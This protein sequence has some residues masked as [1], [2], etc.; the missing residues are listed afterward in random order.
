[1]RAIPRPA[2]RVA[3]ATTAILPSNGLIPTSPTVLEPAE[4]Q[5]APRPP[6]LN[7]DGVLLLNQDLE[8]VKWHEP[9]TS[10]GERCGGIRGGPSRHVAAR[11][12]AT[13]AGRD[14]DRGGAHAGRA[15]AAVWL[16]A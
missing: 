11:P 14:R 10:E 7:D 6:I 3:P 2:P 16:E 13:D 8:T 4:W 15:G 1:M 9:E 5:D 12:R